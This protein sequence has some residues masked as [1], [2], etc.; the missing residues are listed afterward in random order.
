MEILVL[1]FSE[2]VLSFKNKTQILDLKMKWN[3]LGT[4]KDKNIK[5]YIEHIEYC[6]TPLEGLG[7]E[8]KTNCKV[9]CLHFSKEMGVV[10]QKTKCT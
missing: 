7:V 6:N 2:I 8:I 3:D 1:L 4:Y 5:M 9:L 10:N